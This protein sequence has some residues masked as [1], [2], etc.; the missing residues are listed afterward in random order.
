MTSAL[1]AAQRS[2]DERGSNMMKGIWRLNYGLIL[3]P[4][5][6]F[7]V[8]SD[9]WGHTFVLHLPDLPERRN[10]SVLDCQERRSCTNLRHL[11]QYHRLG[12]SPNL[13]YKPMA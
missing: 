4:L 11:I 13:L 12:G 7:Q 1:V 3:K 10:R 2:S 5:D 6:Y 9:T 8:V